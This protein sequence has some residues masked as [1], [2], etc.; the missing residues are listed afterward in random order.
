MDIE[1]SLQTALSFARDKIENL[2]LSERDRKVLVL[3]AAGAFVIIVLI[4]FQAFSSINTKLEKQSSALSSQLKQIEQLKTEYYESKKKV[5][6]IAGSME[7]T[8]QSLLSHMERIL[9]KEN[10]E[11]ASFSINSRNPITKEHYEEVS[12]EVKIKKIS[13][14]KVLDVIHNIQTAPTFLKVSK[15]RM[16]TRFDKPNLMDVSFKVS[17]F[18]FNQV[19]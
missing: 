17:N 6:E 5:S 3:G 11:R 13:L 12:V 16:A 19:I 10:I 15:F 7:S 9:V 4:L 1:N 14:E 2:N 8:D 18:K